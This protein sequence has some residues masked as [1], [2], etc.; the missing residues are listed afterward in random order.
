MGLRKAL[1]VVAAVIMAAAAVALL[2]TQSGRPPMGTP[3]KSGPNAPTG[4]PAS[5]GLTAPIYVVGPQQLVRRLVAVGVPQSLIRSVD[6]SNLSLVPPGSAVVVDWGYLLGHLGGKALVVEPL[7]KGGDLVVVAVPSPD[8][9][10]AAFNALAVAWARAY[11]SKFAMYP[12]SAGGF[13]AAAFGDGHHLIF[14]AGYNATAIPAFLKLYEDVKSAWAR[15]LR[16]SQASFDIHL[17][18]SSGASTEDPCY[19]YAKQYNSYGVAFDFTPDYDGQPRLAYSDV[20]GSLYY[21][22]CVFVYNQP[23]TPSGSPPYYGINPAVWLAYTPTGATINNYGGIQYFIGTVDHESGWNDY[24][25]GF[26]Q[27]IGIPINSYTEYVAGASPQSTSNYQSSFSV[28]FD[29][30]AGP[31]IITYTYSESPSSVQ[32]TQEN[33]DGPYLVAFNNTW[34]FFFGGPQGAG[35]AYQV[36]YTEQQTA[37]VLPQGLNSAQNAALYE[38]FGV[39]LLTSAQWLYNCYDQ[40]NY[41][42]IWTDFVWALEYLAP[43]F[44]YQ[45]TTINWQYPYYISGVSASSQTVYVG[46]VG[47]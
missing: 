42:Y 44:S 3:A 19:A 45:Y 38:E 40:Y 12:A 22:T 27:Y 47:P 41:E 18:S 13:Y 8:E 43:G 9:A 36:A 23:A 15:A 20:N 24:N 37:W 30:G 29:F 34:Y 5:V 17:Q 2:T 6:V 21:D 11:G 32:I 28:T 39:N 25:N 14:T 1:A 4:S 33:T 31:N 10:P 35:Q 46:C 16:N 26:D 7:L